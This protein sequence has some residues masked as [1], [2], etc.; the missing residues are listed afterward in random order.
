[1]I[2]WRGGEVID[3]PKPSAFGWLRVVVRGVLILSTI[4]GLIL[5]ML[6]ARRL[7]CKRASERIGQFASHVCLRILGLRAEVQGTPSPSTSAYAVNHISWLDIFVL[8]AVEHVYFVSKSEVGGWPVVGVIARSAGTVFIQRRSVD[9]QRQLSVIAARLEDGD[10]LMM[11]PEGTSSDGLRVLRFKPTLFAPLLDNSLQGQAVL[12]PV[13][14]FYKSPDGQHPSLY[15]WWGD[16]GLAEHFIALAALPRQGRVVVQFH[17]SIP[18]GPGVD[19]KTL[20]AEAET[21]VRR[22]FDA[23]AGRLAE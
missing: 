10:R 15:S 19:R 9:V 3:L 23:L 14:I 1:M 18:A 4:F 6:L 5:P 11:F 2:T 13:T 21:A 8:N 16:M 22:G 17:D 20:A 7:G 12:Q